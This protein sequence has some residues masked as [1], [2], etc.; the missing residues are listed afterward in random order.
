MNELIV[1]NISLTNHSVYDRRYWVPRG[2]LKDMHLNITA[3]DYS[4]SLDQP[5]IWNLLQEHSPQ[6]YIFVL[7]SDLSEEWDQV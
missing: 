6:N 3:L 5:R 7:S 1:K 2:T 4:K